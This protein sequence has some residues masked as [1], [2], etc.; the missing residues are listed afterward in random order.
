M[1]YTNGTGKEGS[2]IEIL[3]E[4]GVRF[5]TG[6]EGEI[7]DDIWIAHNFTV[8]G[9]TYRVECVLQQWPVELPD[10]SDID[11]RL[12]SLRRGL[13]RKCNPLALDGLNYLV[14]DQHDKL[15]E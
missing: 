9:N 10:D 12:W 6:Q 7:P 11:R 13:N 1:E 5:L 8:I 2:P 15:G 3:T 4:D 14:L